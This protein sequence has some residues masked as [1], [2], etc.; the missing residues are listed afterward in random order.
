[1]LVLRGIDLPT[2]SIGR[3]PESVGV[4]QVAGHYVVIRHQSSAL[5]PFFRISVETA[6]QIFWAELLFTLAW[7]KTDSGR[8][9]TRLKPVARRG[10]NCVYNRFCHIPKLALLFQ[11]D[12]L[13]DDYRN[14][15]RRHHHRAR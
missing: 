13:V 8:P 2:K 5:L 12:R 1:M 10:N 11:T 7:D 14:L 6:E 3:L 4:V 15:E 9:K